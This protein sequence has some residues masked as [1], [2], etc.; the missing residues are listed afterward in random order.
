MLI[1]LRY[2]SVVIEDGSKAITTTTALVCKA[3][4][5]NTKNNNIKDWHFSAQ[6]QSDVKRYQRVLAAKSIDS[7]LLL[8]FHNFCCVSASMPV[9]CCREILKNS[10]GHL[11]FLTVSEKMQININRETRLANL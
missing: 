1:Q 6:A 10:V 11:Q 9:A 2:G 5:K 4:N 8:I 3:N 7:T